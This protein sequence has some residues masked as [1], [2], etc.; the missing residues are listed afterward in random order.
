MEIVKIS[1]SAY[2]LRDLRSSLNVG[3]V[4]TSDGAIL[5]DTGCTAA[6]AAGIRERL[7]QVTAQPITYVVNAHACGE[8]ALSGAS[9]DVPVIAHQ[10][11]Y[12][13]IE[14]AR[15]AAE[16]AGPRGQSDS[17]RASASRV[18]T[19]MAPLPT[20]SFTED[21]YLYVG[22]LLLELLH[23]PGK[24]EGTLAVHLPDEQ[25][26]FVGDLLDVDAYPI[27]QQGSAFRWR[28]T[29]VRL[30]ALGALK[31][32]AARGRLATPED[33]DRHVAHLQN[34]LASA[35]LF[36]SRDEALES[37]AGGDPTS[38]PDAAALFEKA[39]TDR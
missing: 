14:R 22:G 25:V 15:A 16:R 26:L 5:I 18:A 19:G 37:L 33:V 4:I 35:D 21:G 8:V 1:Q 6:M 20:V 3:C 36:A 39:A 17:A 34:V 10:A 11:C 24:G 23:A 7:S 38:E 31:I 13:A 30:R 2:V 29:L 32:V 28:E 27:V 9:F 12:Q